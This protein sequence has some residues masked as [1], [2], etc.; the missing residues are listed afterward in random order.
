MENKK[1]YFI[2]VVYY[3]CYAFYRRYEKDLNEFSGQALTSVCLSL[4]LVTIIILIQEI[5]K[6]S[7]FE[8]KWNTLLVSLPVLL[9]VIIRY[10]K[11]INIEEIEDSLNNKKR[12]LVKKL[13]FIAVIYVIISIFGFLFLMIILGELNNPPPFW[14][15]WFN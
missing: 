11:Y 6:L 8:N 4:N 7:F 9:L 13:N 14:S 10:N 15:N 2:D 12:Y 1:I 3:N 5:F